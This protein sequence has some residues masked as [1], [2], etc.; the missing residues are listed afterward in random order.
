MRRELHQPRQ[1][2]APAAAQ[3]GDARPVEEHHRRLQGEQREHLHE[4]GADAEVGEVGAPLAAEGRLVRAQR[5]EALQG[6]EDRAVEDHVQQEPVDPEERAARDLPVHGHPRPAQQRGDQR[7]PDARHPQR[8]AAAQ[9]HADHARARRT[10]PARRAA[11]RARRGWDTP[12]AAR[13]WSAAR[14]TGSTA[15]RPARAGRGRWTAS[16]SASRI[17]NV[18]VRSVSTRPLCPPIGRTR[19]GRARRRS[20]AY[21]AGCF[22]AGA[23]FFSG[24]RFVLVFL[25]PWPWPRGRRR[26]RLGAGL[27]QGE[28]L[29]RQASGS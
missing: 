3:A 8:L 24:R 20:G 10:R 21:R 22:L 19:R 2:R 15:P 26:L 1:R 18:W 28:D 14:G 6:N 27:A 13:A 7:E 29:H 17:R 12:R 5:E 9:A 23:F 16:R 25:P 11:A 4:Q